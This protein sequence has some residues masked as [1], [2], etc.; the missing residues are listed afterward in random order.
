MRNSRIL[1]FYQGKIRNSGVTESELGVD[2]NR[3]MLF[4]VASPSFAAFAAIICRHNQFAALS[5]PQPAAQ[6][7]ALNFQPFFVFSF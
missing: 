6:P 7:Q 5:V 1:E 3:S 4:N 2:R